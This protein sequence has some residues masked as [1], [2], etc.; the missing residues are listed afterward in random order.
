M[1]EKMAKGALSSLDE[2]LVA[3]L[4]A[5]GEIPCSGAAIGAGL[6]IS[7]AAVWKHIQ[8]LR[9]RG[10]RIEALHRRG[11]RLLGE[12]DFPSL[13]R[14]QPY[15]TAL[16]LL[17]PKQAYF[18]AETDSTNARASQLA[19]DGAPEGTLCCADAQS[20]GRGRMQRVW[21][22]PA[23]ENLYFS[24]VL[25]PAIAPNDAAQI[26]LLAGLALAQTLRDDLH[27]ED[28]YLKWPNDILIGGRKVAGI[29]TEMMA[30]PERVRY[31]VVG[32]GVNVNGRVGDM[33]ADL[34]CIAT[35]LR[36]SSGRSFDRSQLL[37]RFL[38]RLGYW[39]RQFLQGGFAP[40]RESWLQ[41]G[42]IQGRRVRVNFY[43]ES[44]TGVAESMDQNGCLLVTRDDTG[45]LTTVVAGDVNLL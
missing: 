1:V 16:S 43:A 32:V 38:D 28:L 42:D 7:R 29:L 18:F 15:L 27:I 19:R 26:T 33:P 4:V 35:T 8:G 11:Y 40:L 31:I 44:F 30:E 12:P 5:H 3:L 39:Y 13:E 2:K 23:G 45:A 17:H 36:E 14:M 21:V 22:S 6:G 41:Y 25:K 20:G 37:A 34:Q 24:V 9:Q 10:Y